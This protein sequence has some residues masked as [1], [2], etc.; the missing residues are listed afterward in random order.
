METL[1]AIQ[2]RRSIR[3]FKPT[4]VSEELVDKIL[5]AAMQAP[6][7]GNQQPWHFVVIT[8]R[9]LLKEI[10]KFSPYASMAKDAPLAILVCGDLA[11]EKYKGFWVQDCSAAIQNI[12]LASHDLNLGAVWTASYPMPD[13]AEGFRLLCRLPKDIIALALIVIGYPAEKVSA[14]N[15]FRRERVHKNTW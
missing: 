4:R 8:D 14:E 7:A 5:G 6:S 1:K 9:E 2:T 11:M 12:L 15:R 10:P 3:K 13:R